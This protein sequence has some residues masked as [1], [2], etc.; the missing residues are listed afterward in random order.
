MTIEDNKMFDHILEE[1]QAKHT[2]LYF[3]SSFI[4]KNEKHFNKIGLMPYPRN[5]LVTI[6]ATLTKSNF[7]EFEKML[8]FVGN[9]SGILTRPKCLIIIFLDVDHPLIYKEFLDRMWKNLFL[10]LTILEVLQENVTIHQL[11]PFISYTTRSFSRQTELFPDKLKNLNRYPFKVGV[12]D[13]P[14]FFLLKSKNNSIDISGPD[15]S[16]LKEFARLM[17]FKISFIQ[18]NVSRFGKFG[19]LKSKTSGFLL[20]L[21]D[22]RIRMVG[23]RSITT[24]AI[25]PRNLIESMDFEMDHYVFLFPLFK[26]TSYQM[27]IGSSF[28]YSLIVIALCAT[29]S[30]T[31]EYFGK[32]DKTIWNKFAILQILLGLGLPREPEKFKEKCFFLVFLITSFFWS[33]NIISSLTDIQFQVKEEIKMNTLTDLMK[34]DLLISCSLNVAPE[35]RKVVDIEKVGEW[36]KDERIVNYEN[37]IDVLLSKRN[38]ACIMKLSVADHQ[39]RGTDRRKGLKHLDHYLYSSMN[40]FLMEP[41]SPFIG[42]FSSLYLELA[43]AGLVE[44]WQFSDRKN[45]NSES[46]DENEEES[47]EEDVTVKTTSFL[48]GIM[49]IGCSAS[50]L[51]FFGELLMMK[52]GK[53]SSTAWN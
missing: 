31:V 10:D 14:P 17:N 9:S 39:T 37:C 13:S 42:K 35:M 27:S 22:H 6:V 26:K 53:R 52:C 45:S 43:S 5:T 11:N 29:I 30:W 47:T 24:K 12:F 15:A 25:C 41:G 51:A 16:V 46:T 33:S 19:C 44:K 7:S 2:V 1:F 8:E 40:A 50:F 21:I 20:D 4:A 49:I 3:N 32:F 34:S 28:Y 48:L 23:G 38:V 18:S 36:W